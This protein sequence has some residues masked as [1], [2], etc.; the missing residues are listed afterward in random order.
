MYL[1]AHCIEAHTERSPF[2]IIGENVL[3]TA[4]IKVFVGVLF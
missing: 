2:K 3:K 4:E 1:G